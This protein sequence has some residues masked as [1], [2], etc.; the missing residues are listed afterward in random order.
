LLLEI[1]VEHGAPAPRGRRKTA[2]GR[3]PPGGPKV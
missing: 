3:I 2:V 1:D